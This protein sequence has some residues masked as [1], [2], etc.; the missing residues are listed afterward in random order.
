L[1]N[2][3]EHQRTPQLSQPCMFNTYQ[4][5]I[6]NTHLFFCSVRHSFKEIDSQYSL[7]SFAAWGG[8]VLHQSE[9]TL[10]LVARCPPD[11]SSS[12]FAIACFQPHKHYYAE[13]IDE[14]VRTGDTYYDGD[15]DASHRVRCVRKRSRKQ[16]TIYSA[17]A[18]HNKGKQAHRLLLGRCGAADGLNAI[19]NIRRRL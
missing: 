7:Q 9:G 3:H 4:H 14:A 1:A 12:H 19:L 11:S 10:H 2:F 13:A 16:R 17:G 6:R 15:S 18:T 5:C 8:V